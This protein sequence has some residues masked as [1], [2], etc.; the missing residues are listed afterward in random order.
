MVVKGDHRANSIAD[1]EF[2]PSTG[3]IRGPCREVGVWGD[4]PWLCD[5]QK[6]S[7]LHTLIR[8]RH[9]T[10]LCGGHAPIAERT[11]NPARMCLESLA[12]RPGIREQ[13]GSYSE[14][15]R[16]SISSPLH[17]QKSG[18]LADLPGR[19]LGANRISRRCLRLS[20]G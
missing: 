3:G 2:P 18:H 15:L 1:S 10:P 8:Q 11:M 14:E 12:R 5:A 7:A 9:L 17:P 16:L 6:A 20:D 13:P 4:R 19:P